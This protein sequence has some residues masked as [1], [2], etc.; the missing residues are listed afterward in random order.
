MYSETE[1]EELRE[2]YRWLSD[3]LSVDERL[4]LVAFIKSLPLAKQEQLRV[5]QPRIHWLS[6]L[7]GVV[8]AN[9]FHA[10]KP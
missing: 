4:A 1:L 10:Q 7:A 6:H 5:C 2:K 8:H 9:R 3:L